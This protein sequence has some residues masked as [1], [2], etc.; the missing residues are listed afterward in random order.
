MADSA[1]IRRPWLALA[2]VLASPASVAVGSTCDFGEEHEVDYDA[3]MA[4]GD[5][6][7]SDVDLILVVRK[8]PFDGKGPYA[9]WPRKLTYDDS[10]T[11][12]R[13]SRD[14]VEVQASILGDVQ[15]SHIELWLGD[16]FSMV[17]PEL[18]IVFV[19]LWNL[20][21]G[22][23]PAPPTPSGVQ[24]YASDALHYDQPFRTIHVRDGRLIGM[25]GRSFCLRDE[26]WF[27]ACEEGEDSPSLD[28][29][30]AHLRTWTAGA[31]GVAVEGFDP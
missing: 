22:A 10:L 17:A 20:E 15:R 31:H 23:H 25:D 1:P 21:T 6:W 28:E 7:M 19:S 16:D 12:G 2:A 14:V 4:D 29:V 26:G 11:P 3:L 5:W 9:P 30:V 13:I 18:G 8:V 24:F 27:R